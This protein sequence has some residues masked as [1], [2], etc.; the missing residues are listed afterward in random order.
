MPTQIETANPTA[1]HARL[2]T[3]SELID[4]LAHRFYRSYA[5]D[6]PSFQY[7]QTLKS[8]DPLGLRK[9]TGYL[10]L[11]L[12]SDK[13]TRVAIRCY[14]IKGAVMWVEWIALA[15]GVE[16]CER[17]INIDTDADWDWINDRV[18]KLL[19]VVRE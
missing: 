9:S 15:H 8:D 6:W 3:L 18:R 2:E 5:V 12:D 1:S 7:L 14:A 17:D 10:A 13:V 4:T 11:R 19:G 16:P